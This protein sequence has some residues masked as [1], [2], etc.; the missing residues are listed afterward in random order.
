[1][2]DT[3]HICLTDKILE[4]F[5]S[6]NASR[7]DTDRITKDIEDCVFCKRKYIKRGLKK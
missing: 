7:E 6:H 4:K 2:S 1:M 5:F 3:D